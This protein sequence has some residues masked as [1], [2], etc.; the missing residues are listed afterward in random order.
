MD[1]SKGVVIP[2][3]IITFETIETVIG[4]IT[5]LFIVCTIIGDF[6]KGQTKNT[7][8]KIVFSLTCSNICLQSFLFVYTLA[9][10]FHF[11]PGSYTKL[12][13]LLLVTYG[14]ISCM[15]MSMCLSFFHCI[16]I[17]QF[18]SG[19]FSLVKKKIDGL[20]PWMIVVIQAMS[21]GCS[22][23][24]APS[25]VPPQAPMNMNNISEIAFANNTEHSNSQEVNIVYYINF[26]PFLM[27]VI[28][29]AFTTISLV[30]HVHRMARTSST[31]SSN[32]VKT[33]RVVWTLVQLLA[34][35]LIFYLIMMVAF[36]VQMSTTYFN[37][38]FVI[39]QFAFCPVQSFILIF[40]NPSY[41]E[42]CT[43]VCCRL[44]RYRR[45]LS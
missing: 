8:D 23:L 14:R 32:T 28:I 5:S 38:F 3:I 17:I 16:K 42:I 10:T 36:S 18:R 25:M 12:I 30:V 40:G 22:F 41:K 31:S 27:A 33:R 15:W 34:L 26:G 19:F 11:N 6:L 37:D 29:T 13:I 39:L 4:L 2:F 44:R 21:L 20:I 45:K 43:A 24:T 1:S 35:Y 9:I 7:V